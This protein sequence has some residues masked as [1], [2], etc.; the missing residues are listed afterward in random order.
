MVYFVLRDQPMEQ[1]LIAAY[2][3]DLS[4]G[5]RLENMDGTIFLNGIGWL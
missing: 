2:N 5:H 3:S 4:A 1:N